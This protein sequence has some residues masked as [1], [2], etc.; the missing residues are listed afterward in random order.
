MDEFSSVVKDD[1]SRI[2][3]LIHEILGYARYMEPKVEEENINDIIMSCILFVQ[4][5]AEREGIT[6]AHELADNL[7]RMLLDRQQIKQV[8]LN[9]LLNAMDAITSGRAELPLELM[10]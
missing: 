6:I 10:F 3:R 4:V 2:E 8:V 7:P 1:V 9:L 5:K